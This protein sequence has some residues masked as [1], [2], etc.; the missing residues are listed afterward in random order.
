MKSNTL[1][2]AIINSMLMHQKPSVTWNDGSLSF[3]ELEKAKKVA[4]RHKKTVFGHTLNVLDA[5]TIKNPITLW[6]ALFHDLGKTYTQTMSSDGYY[7]FHGHPEKSAIIAH[8]I[9]SMWGEDPIVI[10][11]VERIILTHMLDLKNA[12]DKMAR[13]LF[14]KV[15]RDNISNWFAVRE[16][17]VFAYPHSEEYYN[18]YV[19]NFRQKVDAYGTIL[20]RENDLCIPTTDSVMHICGGK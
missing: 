19:I 5:L 8:N 13:N 16:A 7:F 17:D 6:A 14:G 10:D 9:L 12:G 4:Q 11:R 1:A 3:E 15:G 18:K 20:I 2:I